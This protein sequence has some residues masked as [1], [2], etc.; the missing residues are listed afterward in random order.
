MNTF[1]WVLQIILAVI[2][3]VSGVMKVTRPKMKLEPQMGFVEDF[4]SRSVKLIGT[5][6]VLGALGLVLPAATGVAT[7]LTPLAATGLVI[8]MAGAI[9]VHRRR[10]ESAAAVVPAV[11][12]VLSLVVAIGR[13]GLYPL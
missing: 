2:Y 1:L 5:A 6:E 13:F 8:L 4:S 10:G 7:V 3:I 11:L 9:V 12:L